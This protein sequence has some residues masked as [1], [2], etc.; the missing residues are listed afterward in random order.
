MNGNHS[1]RSFIAFYGCIVFFLLLAPLAAYSDFWS[2]TEISPGIRFWGAD[3][4]LRY[5]G[6]PLTAPLVTRWCVVFGGGY[7]DPGYYRNPDS[8]LYTP[9]YDSSQNL[10]IYKRINYTWGLG[11]KQGILL[12]E[13]KNDNLLEAYLIYRGRYDEDVQSSSPAGSLIFGSLIPDKLGITEHSFTAGLFFDSVIVHPQ[14]RKRTGVSV[15][16]SGE[17]A[18]Q[19]LNSIADFGRF[20]FDLRSYLTVLDATHEDPQSNVFNAYFCNRIVFDVVGGPMVPL[21]ARQTVGGRAM[22]LWDAFGYSMRGIDDRRYDS[23]LKL[24]VNTDFRMN[25]PSLPLGIVPGMVIYFDV[26]TSD[27]DNLA[28]NMSLS[29]LKYTCGIGESLY[30]LGFDAVLYEN[31]YINENRFNI[32]F[33]FALQF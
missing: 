11:L 12:D 31:Y 7:E 10:A 27:A 13:R 1:K 25:F 17:Y 28:Y 19:F 8:S 32:S 26:G 3:L 9:P 22:E 6:L 18:P 15:D 20:T 14:Q 16:V 2:D 4:E 30:I 23:N 21:N 29:N 5:K 24:I 33:Y